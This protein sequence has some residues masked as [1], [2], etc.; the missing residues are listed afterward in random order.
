MFENKGLVSVRQHARNIVALTL[1]RR[2]PIS[3]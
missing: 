1:S 3:R 2:T